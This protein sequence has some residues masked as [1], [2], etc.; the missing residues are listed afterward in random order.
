[1]N[2][3]NNAIKDLMGLAIPRKILNIA[4]MAKAKAYR[5]N[6]TLEK[7]INDLVITPHVL[8][9]CNL[10]GGITLTIDLNKCYISKYINN[11]DNENC[12]ITVPDEVL[13]GRKIIQPLSVTTNFSY[14][15]VSPSYSSSNMAINMLQSV[16][17]TTIGQAPGDV[18]TDLT[19]IARNTILI[20][21][22]IFDV[23]DG[24]IEVDVE[25]N[26]NLS[27]ISTRSYPAFSVLVEL[28]VKAYIYNELVLELEDGSLYYGHNV[29]KLAEKVDSYESAL[30]EYREYLKTTWAKV[31]NINN[32]AFMS[33]HVGLLVGRYKE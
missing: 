16:S 17:D 29:S 9:D 6:T 13:S 19:L 26:A 3:V 10:V 4:F 8:K 2:A 33:E 25:N 5:V 22:N 14:S 24:Y 21:E 23:G 12:I 32:T 18:Y 28:A 30:E 1:M 31:A 7:Q 11:D 20:E 27:N 15:N